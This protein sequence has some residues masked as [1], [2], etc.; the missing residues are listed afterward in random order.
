MSL[1]ESQMVN[2]LAAATLDDPDLPA[3]L[4]DAGYQI[5]AIEKEVPLPSGRIAKFDLV[6]SSKRTN[7]S[8]GF[9]CKGGGGPYDKDQAERYAQVQGRDLVRFAQ[10]QHTDESTHT[11]DVAYCGNA[12]HTAALEE[13]VNDH[14]FTILVVV[15]TAPT[16]LRVECH[17]DCFT[18]RALSRGLSGLKLS[19]ESIPSIVRFG[20][21]TPDHKVAAAC[22]QIMLEWARSGKDVFVR[23]ELVETVFSPIPGLHLRAGTE[24]M[25]R[26]DETVA[27]ILRR[28]SQSKQL[29]PYIRRAP[30]RA[31]WEIHGLGPE[32]TT[33][34]LQSY[35]RRAKEFVEI[36]R[37]GYPPPDPD[38]LSLSDYH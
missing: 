18:D 21:G 20:P 28:A 4:A 24:L 37:T 14:A 10:V 13:V 11:V 34:T 32:A 2:M 15:D 12:A 36:L 35:L 25:E 5:A 16:M 38:Q 17:R 9:E 26:L 23:Q 31:T 33:T 27:S 1:S 29:R 8:V 22:F 30:D 3:A 19:K 7:H 6:L